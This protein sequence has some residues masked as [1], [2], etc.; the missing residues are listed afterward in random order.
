ME[1]GGVGLVYN[2]CKKEFKLLHPELA[3]NRFLPECRSESGGCGAGR[4][5]KKRKYKNFGICTKMYGV[6]VHN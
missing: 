2:E 5:K 6:Q 3:A 4:G 1:E